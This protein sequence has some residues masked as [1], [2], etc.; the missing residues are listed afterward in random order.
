PAFRGLACDKGA[1]I[2]ADAH[3]MAQLELLGRDQRA[4]VEVS[5]QQCLRVGESWF[6]RATLF[7]FG[8]RLLRERRQQAPGGEHHDFR[9]ALRV[10]EREVERDA[11]GLR[12]AEE[13]SAV[14]LKLYY[15]H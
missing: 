2:L 12:V 3:A 5:L 9:D 7:A 15:E 14:D 6:A 1:E 4:V 10:A 8:F 13:G 11:A